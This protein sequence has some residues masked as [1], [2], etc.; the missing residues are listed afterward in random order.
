[1]P[2]VTGGDALWL[3]RQVKGADWYFVCAP[4]GKGFKGELSFNIAG[5]AE[6]WDPLTGETT[7]LETKVENNRSSVSLD[8]PQ[9]GACFIVFRHNSKNT[10]AIKVAEKS[11]ET[12]AL[13]LNNNWSLSFPGGW[14]APES[15][16][17]DKLEAWK[18]LPVS[19]EGKA[20]SGT[21]TYSVSFNIDEVKPETGYL[22]DLGQVEMIAEVS[23]NGKKLQALWAP[24]Y[25][26]NLTDALIAGKNDLSVKVTSTWFNRLVYDAGQQEENRKTWT[27][28]GPSKDSSLRESGLLGPVKI[29]KL[30]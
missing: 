20:F 10:A 11:S 18:D 19:E 1:V 25:R 17:L 15:L 3:H 16:S 6:F 30:K 9:A 7:P 27:I 24:P 28:S 29:I 4:E 5:S 21:A 8:L 2:D 23:L 26:L 14:G 13:E 12:I 22:L